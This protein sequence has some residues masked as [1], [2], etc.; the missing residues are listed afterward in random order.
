MPREIR[1]AYVLLIYAL[2]FIGASHVLFDLVIPCG[3]FIAK[4]FI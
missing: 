2:V 3:I 1:A 4:A